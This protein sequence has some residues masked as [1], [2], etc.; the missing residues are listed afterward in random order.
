MDSKRGILQK[1]TGI[2]VVLLLAAQLIGC[3][4]NKEESTVSLK[5]H[6]DVAYSY[7][8][9][10]QEN[11]GERQAGSERE[12][13]AFR[14]I[15]SEIEKMGYEDSAITE[16]K[17]KMSTGEPSQNLMIKKEGVSP[18]VIRIGAHYDSVGT[19][20]VDDNGSGVAALMECVRR[21]KK[22]ETP[23]S[24]EFIFFGAEETGLEGSNY[25]VSKMDKKE[26][27]KTLFMVNL[28]CIIAGDKNYVYSGTV[29][30][31]NKVT[32]TEYLPMI[33]ELAKENQIQL[34]VN[35]G[36]NI[37][38]PAPTT[39]GWS[40]HAPFA[41]KG[42]PYIYFEAT[43]WDISPYDGIAETETLGK[44]MHSSNDDLTVLNKVFPNRAKKNLAIF[45]KLLSAILGCSDFE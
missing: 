24:Y 29:L 41:Q 27:E 30:S 8:T 16:Q 21:A 10:F 26:I 17:F 45:S 19:R 34:E 44:V 32:G 7:L 4:G 33:Q 2:V 1:A 9:Y 13:D 28:D 40:D 15:R 36:K 18:K 31:D 23:Y 3:G 38:Y 42:V 43:N 37:D 25:Y 35:P 5:K 20:G 22:I 6:G 12:K 11:L 14:Y 39:G